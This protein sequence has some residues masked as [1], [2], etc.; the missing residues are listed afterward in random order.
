MRIPNALRTTH[1]TLNPMPSRLL[2]T[3][4]IN[5]GFRMP[6]EFEP[7]AGCWMLFPERP[8]VWGNDAKP[9]QQAF[10]N[11]ATAIVRFEP[12]T[13]CAS[14]KSYLTARAL[15]SP[16]VRVVEM[17]SND[18]WMRDCG[19]TFVVNDKG[20]VRGIDWEFN[21]WGGL[22]GGLYYPWDQD[23]L[24]AQKVLDLVRVDR[25]KT[26][27]VN[28]GGAFHVD[29]QGTLVTTRSVLLNANRNPG[30]SQTKVE[31]ILHDYLGVEKVIWLDVS[32]EDETD[33]HVDGVCAF[34]RPGT[35]LLSWCNNPHSPDYDYYQSIY[36]QLASQTD[37]QGRLLQLIKLP[38]AQL[39]PMT[40]AEANAVIDV[41]GT[42]PRSVG[43]PV[44]GGYINFYIANGGIVHPL[45]GTADD[46]VAQRVLQEAFPGRGITGVPGGRQISMSGGNIHCIT[47]QQPQSRG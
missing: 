32:D 46:Q 11:V 12:V 21:A 26:H 24:V 13:V 22:Q 29:G 43:D 37:A 27:L 30:L 10:A 1:H 2:S 19:P 5:D 3:L 33:G 8:D 23:N 16:K 25:Y 18:A 31:Q 15:L 14:A 44:W 45:F 35:L 6:G 34:T 17:S 42:Y 36:D 47:Q 39:A 41:D 20:A 28:E 4:P 7:H 40:R 38:E 9:A